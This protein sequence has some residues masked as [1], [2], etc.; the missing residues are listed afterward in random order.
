LTTMAR[1]TRVGAAELT[2]RGW[3]L[4]G[5]AGGLLIGSRLGGADPLAALA[6][7]AGLLLGFGYLW[8]STHRVALTLERS[9]YPTRPTVGGEGPVALHGRA[10][11]A[12]P[13]L[14]V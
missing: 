2:R 7:G 6:L 1:D 9:V 13:L 5:A 8:V 14:H 12:S 4:T 11:A 3:T 10:T